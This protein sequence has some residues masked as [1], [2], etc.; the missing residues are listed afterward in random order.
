M[1]L[2]LLCREEDFKYFG[3]DKVFNPLIK[4]LKDIEVSGINL[5]DGTV[6]RRTLSAIC[7]DILGSHGI[8]GFVENF[9]KSVNFGDKIVNPSEN[10][11]CQL[12]LQLREKVELVCAQA[13]S[14]GQIAYLQVLIDEYLHTR[15]QSFYNHP[16]KPKHHYISHY[17]DLMF[18]FGPLIRLWTLRFES[19][20]SYFKQC[21]RKSHNFKNLCRTTC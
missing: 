16:L 7:G 8:G 4:D 19:K 14:T 1:Q 18:H 6:Y 21:A 5:P 12:V 11:T 3:L 9:T 17:P 13:V 20:H 10:E 15:W 2:V